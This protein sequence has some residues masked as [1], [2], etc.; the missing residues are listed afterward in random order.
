MRP[1]SAFTLI[2][3]LVVI[4]I[5]VL[6]IAL[7]LPALG[8]SRDAARR[9]VCL[10]NQRQL[11][12]ALNVYATEFKGNVP[13]GYEGNKQFHYVIFNKWYANN[14][15]KGLMTY[16]R[17]YDTK[18]LPG[19]AGYYCST[20]RRPNTA[21]ANTWPPGSNLNDNTRS[22]YSGRPIVDWPGAN[23]PSK[24]ANLRTLKPQT[25]VVAD[26]VSTYSSALGRH[27]RMGVN[28]SYIDGSGRWV[29]M[30]VIEQPLIPQ[31]GSFSGGN[32][33][34]QDQVWQRLD[35]K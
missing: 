32:N 8:K 16:G 28:T 1:R 3:L 11:V 20:N 13:I 19:P 2:E 29:Q 6:L 21:T 10:S 33:A 5:I 24:M 26:N 7:L 17:L 31:E 25:A 18:I 22:D 23:F 14:A 30:A 27:Q 34:L 12:M 35:R 9:V 4:S 15:I